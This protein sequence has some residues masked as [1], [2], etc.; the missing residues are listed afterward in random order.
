M[1]RTHFLTFSPASRASRAGFGGAACSR[2]FLSGA[3]FEG[4]RPIDPNSTKQAPATI[5]QC[6]IA[7]LNLP[8]RVSFSFGF[9]CLREIRNKY[10]RPLTAL[11]VR[12]SFAAIRWMKEFAFEECPQ[13]PIKT[14]LQRI[15]GSPIKHCDSF[16]I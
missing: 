11:T 16:T 14:N 5:N 15:P 12:F 9:T 7:S 10:T 8:S 1:A 2:F 3:A 4:A 13:S 6:G